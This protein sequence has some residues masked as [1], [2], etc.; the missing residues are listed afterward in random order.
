MNPFFITDFEGLQE[1][2]NLNAF[3][4]LLDVA[5]L[6]VSAKTLGLDFER[7][8]AQYLP[9]AQ[10]V[11]ISDNDGKTDSNRAFEE[12][13]ELF[14]QLSQFDF[15]NKT[16]SLEVYSGINDLKRSFEAAKK[17]VNA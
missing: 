4:P 9:C 8:L 13:S 1:F 2:T 5:H 3:N 16:I 6:K 12:Q 17:L 14:E 15:S 11:H 10:Y 7:E